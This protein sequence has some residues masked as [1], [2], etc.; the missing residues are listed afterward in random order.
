MKAD[1]W[2]VG[3]ALMQA[4]SPDGWRGVADASDLVRVNQ[5]A[6]AA[7]REAVAKAKKEQ[8]CTITVPVQ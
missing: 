1:R 2:N 4:D 8:R 5:E 6:L 7:C 3:I